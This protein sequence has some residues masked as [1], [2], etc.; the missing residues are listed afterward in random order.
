[1]KSI[2]D[3]LAE[4]TI[5]AAQAAKLDATLKHVEAAERLAPTPVLRGMISQAANHACSQLVTLTRSQRSLD[6]KLDSVSQL[7]FQYARGIVAVACRGHDTS[8]LEAV[9]LA[10]LGRAT[11]PEG[12]LRGVERAFVEAA[13]AA[14]EAT[15]QDDR[16]RTFAAYVAARDALLADGRRAA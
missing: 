8:A 9:L 2:A 16:A 10:L 11:L 3:I 12:W 5:L 1:M 15:S 4:Q 14:R 13:L 6:D 7:A